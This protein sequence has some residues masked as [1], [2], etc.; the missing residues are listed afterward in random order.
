[1]FTVVLAVVL[2]PRLHVGAL[3]VL[4]PLYFLTLYELT[5][6]LMR[7]GLM[8]SLSGVLRVPA[9]LLKP[10]LLFDLSATLHLLHLLRRVR[11]VR[12]IL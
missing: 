8:R 12:G 10:C 3:P 4:L 11:A 9:L 5:I 6:A 7:R 1:M 2:R